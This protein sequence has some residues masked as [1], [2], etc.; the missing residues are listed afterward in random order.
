MDRVQSVSKNTSYL[1]VGDVIG[2]LISIGISILFVRYLGREELGKYS[3]AM[4]YL[5][6]FSVLPHLSNESILGREVAVVKE[7]QAG[8]FLGDAILLRVILSL[9]AMVLAWIGCTFFEP[10]PQIRL[11]IFIASL[12]M[13]A[14]FR[15]LFVTVFQRTMEMRVFSIVNISMKLLAAV[16][17]LALIILKGTVEHFVLLNIFVAFVS[18][19]LFYTLSQKR[20]PIEWGWDNKRFFSFL[21]DSFPVSVS[22]FF[23]RVIAR[24]DQIFIFS[25]IG[26]SSLG[27]YSAT[28]TV[29]ES[30]LFIPTA[31]LTVLLPVLSV[32]F[33][34]SK[35]K[36]ERSVKI[37]GKYLLL[38][39]L[40]V[41][42]FICFYSKE[43]LIFLFGNSFAEAAPV[44]KILIWSFPLNCML[45]LLRHVLISAKKQKI[46]LIGSL[47]GAVLNIPL[48]MVLIPKM[49]GAG[50]A[51]A[52]TIAYSVP[53]ICFLVDRVPRNLTLCSYF[54]LLKLLPA[55]ILLELFL[56]F[57]TFSWFVA[58]IFSSL[59]YL[60][61]L[62]LTKGLG[63]EDIKL[64]KR[65]IGMKYGK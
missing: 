61:A 63:S 34:E 59:V 57:F 43:V 50:A 62:F 15:S 25:I 16:L 13:I 38:F 1:I 35:D 11:L 52:T 18:A 12:G 53:F 7:K 23:D 30:F 39:S 6:F 14:S 26:I 33:L 21:K 58:L 22:H 55:L 29:V 36:H 40:P 17:T 8:R 5:F 54:G 65:A 41:A 19:A 44:L 48:N 2:K 60:A 32:L 28:V 24:V 3:F 10:T 9:I 42:L 49:G 45:I 4:A 27:L 37:S 56:H 31:L 46:I 64:F 51:L 47:F 20:I